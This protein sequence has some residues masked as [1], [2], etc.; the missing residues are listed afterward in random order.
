VSGG[1]VARTSTTISVAYRRIYDS[2]EVARVGEPANV[3][4][5]RFEKTLAVLLS[6]EVEDVIALKVILTSPMRNWS[7]AARR[8][9]PAADHRRLTQTPLLD[10]HASFPARQKNDSELFLT[11]PPLACDLRTVL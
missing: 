7:N 9:S 2:A 10:V 6:A 3:I 8:W 1:V 5:E 11:G 4:E